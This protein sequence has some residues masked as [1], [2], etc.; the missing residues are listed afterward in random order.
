MVSSIPRDV[1]TVLPCD[2]QLAAEPGSYDV[3]LVGGGVLDLPA[4]P[5]G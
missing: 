3:F 2:T 4:R 1:T 5:A